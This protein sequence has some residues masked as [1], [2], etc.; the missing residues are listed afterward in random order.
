[1]TK[2]TIFPAQYCVPVVGEGGV[3]QFETQILLS[4]FGVTGLDETL[5]VSL[6]EMQV[7]LAKFSLVLTNAKS[8][9]ELSLG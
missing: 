6:L 8:C 1:M 9:A 5:S 7:K 4:H 3:V 2:S